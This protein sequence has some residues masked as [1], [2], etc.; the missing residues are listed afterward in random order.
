MENIE[1]KTIK[2][3]N[4]NSEEYIKNTFCVD[5]SFLYQKFEKYLNKNSK[6]L[7]IGFGSGRDLIYFSKKYE[8]YGIDLCENFVNHLKVMGYTNVTKQ[9]VE[10]FSFDF[11][12][13]GM[14]ACASLL[15]IKKENLNQAIENC[16][17]YLS[18]GGVFYFSFKQGDYCGEI[19]GRY[20][21]YLNLDFLNSILKDL[22]CKIIESFFT[23]D[24][25]KDR[26]EKWINIILQK[27]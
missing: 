16:L 26:N 13:D 24:N 17:K 8:A 21:H 6:I 27:L 19:N 2:Y 7:D 12:F 23:D 3:Y 18:K 14:W 4:D 9:G 5:M 22:N 1:E 25:L 20:Y 11:K 15:H 10:D